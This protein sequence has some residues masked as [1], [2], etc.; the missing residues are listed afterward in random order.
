VHN[1]LTYK[2]I[3]RNI[4][5][6]SNSGCKLLTTENEFNNINIHKNNIKIL[7]GICKEK[8]FVVLYNNFVKKDMLKQ[9]C[10]DCGFKIMV[11]KRK[12][13]KIIKNIEEYNKLKILGYIHINE[14]II[15][16][17]LLCNSGHIFHYKINIDEVLRIKHI[18]IKCT[19]CNTLCDNEYN[20]ILINNKLDKIKKEAI[21]N[22]NFEIQQ[23]NKKVKK[24]Q[25]YINKKLDKLE[26]S[27]IKYKDR[28]DKFLKKHNHKEDAIIRNQKR[29]N[30]LYGDEYTLI[31]DYSGYHSKIA[32]RHN[33]CGNVWNISLDNLFRGR[34]CP[35]C[36]SKSANE[37]KIEEFLKSYNINY[38][39]QYKFEDCRNKQSLPFDFAIFDRDNNFLFLLEYDG[40]QH[41]EAVDW[42]GGIK[43][44]E[45]IKLNDK[46]K[47]N[48]CRDNHIF[49]ARIPYF[50]D[51]MV[52][53]IV[54]KW[55]KK[56]NL[57]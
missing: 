36:K 55:L 31:G 24:E 29:L 41:F 32:V 43:Q 40:K 21:Q 16:F 7:C 57:L 8:E 22:T 27:K 56:Y 33:I 17:R 10:N 1:K 49:L 20:D 35:K 25:R 48:Y 6:E 3:K 34:G 45:Y 11:Y 51:K 19:V 53:K 12:L 50:Q 2:N 23:N 14:S 30:N 18:I 28:L 44:F 39:R 15:K 46:I 47:N 37:D 5:T 42:F 54:K 9:Q 38:I 13:N 52:I 4:E 26:K